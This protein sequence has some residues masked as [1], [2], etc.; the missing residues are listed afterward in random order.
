[1]DG[2]RFLNGDGMVRT[3]GSGNP[4]TPAAWPVARFKDRVRFGPRGHQEQS[5]NTPITDIRKQTRLSYCHFVAKCQISMKIRSRL[6][7]PDPLGE[8]SSVAAGKHERLSVSAAGRRARPGREDQRK[9]ELQ[10]KAMASG[11]NRQKWVARM[12]RVAASYPMPRSPALQRRENRRQEG[13]RLVRIVRDAPGVRNFSSVRCPA[14]QRRGNRIRF[15]HRFPSPPGNE[16]PGC[17]GAADGTKVPYS[18]APA[19]QG[20]MRSGHRFSSP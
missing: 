14:L 7:K 18:G 1:M 5:D 17:R 16:L 9:R 13:R 2:H 4:A 20:K 6:A 15:G 11:G 19:V 3:P 10:H 8:S 12:R